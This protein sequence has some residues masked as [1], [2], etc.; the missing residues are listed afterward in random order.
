MKHLI[1]RNW[2]DKVRE[3]HAFHVS[4]VKLDDH[5]RI[6]DTASILNQSLGSISQYLLLA[7][8][9]KTHETQLRKFRTAN[10]ALEFVRRKK[11]EQRIT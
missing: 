8:W 7:Q 4:Q 1:K 2:I 5:W 6:Q 11:H 9:L 3:I 10:A